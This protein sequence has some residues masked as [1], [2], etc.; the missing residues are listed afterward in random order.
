MNNEEIAK[1]LD[2]AAKDATAIQQMGEKHDFS[3][4]DAYE[5]QRHS[6]NRRL[7][8]GE[9]ITGFKLGFTSRAKMEQMGVHDLIWGILT[10]EM[11]LK[12]QEEVNLDRWI[13]PRA[14]PEIAF[15]ISK[16]IEESIGLKE[17]HKYVDAMAPAL[18]IIDSRYEN[19]KFS[20]EDVVADNCSSTGYVIG[21][22]L[23]L[24]TEISDLDIDLRIDTHVVQSGKTSA[25]LNNP[26]Q[27]LVELSRLAS[28]A[29]I[30]IQ[31]GQVVLAGAATAAVY[32]E[33]NQHVEAQVEELG[34]ISFQ[35]K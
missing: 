30:I 3:L 29:G 17:I 32:L 11:E 25:I 23:D 5:I 28:K 21:D 4:E 33:K 31:E 8:R 1:I 12:P 27:S 20:L 2:Q 6:I 15:R 18:E 24:N 16:D 35:T 10:D 9:K 13:H 26:L 19:F 14:E 22:W 7:D 34:N